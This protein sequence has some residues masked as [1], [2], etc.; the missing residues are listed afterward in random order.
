MLAPALEKTNL[1]FFIS[2]AVDDQRARGLGLFLVF[3]GLG[4]V[5]VFFFCSFKFLGRGIAQDQH[6]ALAV[7]GPGEVFDVLRSVGDALGLAAHAVQQVD[8]SLALAAP[9][10]KGEVLA[11]RAPA[12]MG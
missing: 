8:L 7:G 5:V 6:H 2:E 3:V 11:I 10:E 12:W 4:G 1:V 9:G